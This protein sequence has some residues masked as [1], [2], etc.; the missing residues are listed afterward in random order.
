MT[1]AVWLF[2]PRSHGRERKGARARNGAPAMSQKA[3]LQWTGA[4]TAHARSKTARPVESALASD[5]KMDYMEHQFVQRH[6]GDHDAGWR[7]ALGLSEGVEDAAN[8]AIWN[9]E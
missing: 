2:E 4:L 1:T 7:A 3:R 6:G 9:L 5:S 8:R